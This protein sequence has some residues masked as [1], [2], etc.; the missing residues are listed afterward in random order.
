MAFTAAE[1]A[2]LLADG[3]DSECSSI[4]DDDEN[5]TSLDSDTEAGKFYLLRMQNEIDKIE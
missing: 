2:C 3:S 5:F 1:V 4:T